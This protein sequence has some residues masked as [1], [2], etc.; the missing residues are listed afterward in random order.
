MKSNFK[1][2]CVFFLLFLFFFK[3]SLYGGILWNLLLPVTI[4]FIV[5]ASY[6]AIVNGSKFFVKTG[7]LILFLGISYDLLYSLLTHMKLEKSSG[8]KEISIM[9][10]NLFFKNKSPQQ[11]IKIIKLSNPDILAVQEITPTWDNHLKNELNKSY[12]FKSI[13][14][15]N[16]THG[17]GIYSKYKITHLKNIYNINNRLVAQICEVALSNKKILIINA[18]LASPGLAVENPNSFFNLY[19]NIYNQRVSEY[20]RILDFVLSKDKEYDAKILVGDL[21]T[22]KY[23]SL[24]KKM[25][26][27]WVNSQEISGELFRFNFPNSHN[28]IPIITIDYILLRGKI[29]SLN[30]DVISGGSSDHL[31]ILSEIRI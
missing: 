16:G 1:R 6:D 22:M 2:I 26:K 15:Q 9:T 5:F 25:K 20:E 17:L 8:S 11:P 29:E 30:T 13:F 27:D 31:A 28:F 7:L 23:E 12:P 14:P 21:N 24:Y 19:H 10:Y 4:I 3:S 18:H